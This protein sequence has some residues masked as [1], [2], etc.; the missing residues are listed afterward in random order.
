MVYLGSMYPRNIKKPQKRSFLLFGPRGTGKSSWLRKAF[1]KAPYVDL[2]D[3]EIFRQL[4][5]RPESLSNYFPSGSEW[6]VIDEVQRVPELLN[7]VHRLIELNG[8]K[9]AISGSSARKLKAVGTNLLAGRAVTSFMYPFISDE[10]GKDFSLAK[11]LRLGMLPE[12]WD[13]DDGEAYLSSYVTTYLKEE[14]QQEGLT[15][16]LGVFSRFLEIASFSQASPL[17]VSAVSRELGVDNKTAEN[18]FC[19]L[20]DLL[21][22]T[23]LPV[24]SKHAKR[25]LYSRP[26]F[27][28]FDVG[29]FR[30][31][32]PKGPLDTPELIDGAALETLLYQHLVALNEYFNLGYQIYYWK[33]RAKEE[34]DFVLYGERGILAFEVKRSENIRSK[35][36]KS[37]KAFVEDYPQAKPFL[38][39][40]GRTRQYIDGI[41]LIPYEEGLKE[42]KGLLS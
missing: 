16:S 5:S 26:K 40:G 36:L 35:D 12:V 20:E 22:A 1:S 33:T 41:T 42:L 27:L 29:V 24:F 31:L 2:L 14:V 11:A 19:I 25:Q 3:A 4:S 21:L 6:V 17:N 10:L 7:E 39:Y 18:Y 37:L 15:R 34:V 23:R 38:V 9:F 8:T 30:T 28:F 32:R 13:G